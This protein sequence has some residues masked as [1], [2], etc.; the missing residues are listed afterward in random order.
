MAGAQ[1]GYINETLN[2]F[3]HRP[4]QQSKQATLLPDLT[5]AW[6]DIVRGAKNAGYLASADLEVRALARVAEHIQ[7]RLPQLVPDNLDRTMS[8]LTKIAERIQEL[9]ERQTVAD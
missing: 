2:C 9:G 5:L 7:S 3:R 6:Y 1:L 8:V 4:G